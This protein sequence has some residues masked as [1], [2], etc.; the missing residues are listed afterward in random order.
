MVYL[1][2]R[3]FIVLSGW[4]LMGVYQGFWGNGI[5]IYS[6]PLRVTVVYE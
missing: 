4:M 6:G 2:Y 3:C 5:R 1:V